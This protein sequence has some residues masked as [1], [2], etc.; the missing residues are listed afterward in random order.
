MAFILSTN[1]KKDTHFD[2][3]AEDNTIEQWF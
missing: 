2:Y 1:R 3:S